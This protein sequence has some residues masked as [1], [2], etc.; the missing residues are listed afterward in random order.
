MADSTTDVC[1]EAALECLMYL[2]R[3]EDNMAMKLAGLTV[4]QEMLKHNQGNGYVRIALLK[5][6]LLDTL[7]EAFDHGLEEE[8]NFAFLDI[9][10]KCIF[11]LSKLPVSPVQPLISNNVIRRLLL[12]LD[13]KRTF[14]RFSNKMTETCAEMCE[15]KHLVSKVQV[16]QMNAKRW[17][18]LHKMCQYAL[19]K[20]KDLPT[21]VRYCT[22]YDTDSHGR[23]VDIGGLLVQGDLAWAAEDDGDDEGTLHVFIIQLPLRRAMLS[24]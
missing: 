9:A 15:G 16:V 20:K 2:S 3:L 12:L 17:M 8:C 23:D 19:I 14:F 5:K 13:S 11:Y 22:V 21:S 6:G 24:V 1:E 4:L 10:V 18:K 7:L